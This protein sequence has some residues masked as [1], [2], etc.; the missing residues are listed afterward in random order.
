MTDDLDDLDDEAALALQRL[1]IAH[2]EAMLTR[3]RDDD[4]D[5]QDVA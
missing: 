1:R 4:P 2:L 3:L 5:P